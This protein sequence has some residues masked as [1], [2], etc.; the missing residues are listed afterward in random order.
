[1]RV[2]R[3]AIALLVLLVGLLGAACSGGDEG[4]SGTTEPPDVVIASFGF[5]ESVTVAEIYGQALEATGVRVARVMDLGSRETVEPAL[6]QGRVDLVPEYLGTALTFLEP[7][8]GTAANVSTTYER[9]RA[10]FASRGSVL[11]AK[12][13]DLQPVAARLVFGGPPECPERPLC[14]PGLERVYGLRFKEFKPLDA[15]GPLTV[16]ALEGAEVDVAVLFTSDGHL[17]GDQFVLLQDDRGL[18]PPDNLVPVMRKETVD[19]L[20][21]RLTQVIDRVSA[22]LHTKDLTELNRR[23]SIEGVKPARAAADWL[24]SRGLV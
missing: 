20:G 17:D 3:A 2:T 7:A 6:E 1:V 21:P 13:S 23:V 12:I 22:S 8:A 14:L 5:S 19:R 4:G 24:R 16:G 9:A 11:L 18:Q 15:G 10:A